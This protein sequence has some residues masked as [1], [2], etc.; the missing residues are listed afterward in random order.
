[1]LPHRLR[2]YHPIS[3]CAF[4]MAT[5]M[6]AYRDSAFARGVPTP[7]YNVRQRQR[8]ERTLSREGTRILIACGADAPELIMGWSI[9]S[10]QR[11]H[12][13]YVKLAYRQQGIGSSLLTAMHDDGSPMFYSSKGDVWIE[14]K[15][16]NEDR[17]TNWIY[18]PYWFEEEENK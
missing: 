18:D 6:R 9:T 3:D 8:I 12:Y 15:L 7:I 1:M 4:V 5:W 14:K 2:D 17:W 11:L 16:Q 10:P 13:I